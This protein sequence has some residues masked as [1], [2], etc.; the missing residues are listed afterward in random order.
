MRLLLTN[1]SKK[2]IENIVYWYDYQRKG[3]GFDFFDSLE[4]AFSQISQFP[5]S[6]PVVYQNF[7]RCLLKRFPYSIFYLIEDQQLVVHAV[8]NHRQD[9][10]KSVNLL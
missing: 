10:G 6:Y 4:N 8:L 7:R 3:L 5:E 2:D 1:R 9:V